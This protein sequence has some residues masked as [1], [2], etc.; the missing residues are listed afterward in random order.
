MPTKVKRTKEEMA[1]LRK[2]IKAF[3]VEGIAPIEGSLLIGV[4]YSTYYSLARK[5][6]RQIKNT[7]KKGE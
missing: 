5:I 6:Q 3:V 2:A 7:T 1:L 4:S